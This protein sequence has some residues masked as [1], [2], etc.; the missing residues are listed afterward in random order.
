MAKPAAFRGDSAAMK[1]RHAACSLVFHV[2]TV[3]SSCCAGTVC[4][5]A[6]AMPVGRG[7]KACMHVCNDNA[8]PKSI[9]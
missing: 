8:L 6:D 5:S 3:V 4:A 7:S 2:T 1:V 9:C